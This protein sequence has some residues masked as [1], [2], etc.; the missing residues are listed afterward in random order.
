M[1]CGRWRRCRRP[2]EEPPV[3]AQVAAPVALPS[4]PTPSDGGTKRP[5]LRALK[6]MG[7]TEDEDVR[8]MLLGSRLRKIRSRTWHK[9]RLYRLQEDGL[10]VWFQRRIPR[11]PSQHIFFVQHIEAVREGHQSEGLRRFGGAFAPARCLTIAFKGRRKNLDLAAPTAEEAQRWVRGLTKLRARLDAMSQRER[12]DHW[13][14]SYLHRADSNQDSKMSFKEIKSLLRM[15]NVDMNDMYAYLLF[16]E[17]DH[18]NNDRLEGAEIEEFLRRLLKRPELEEIF[19]QYS[20]EDRVLS[21]PELLEFL[22]DQGEEG[23]TLARAQQLIQTYELN[24]TAKQHELM[25][26]DGF[27]M[28]LLSPEGAA[29]DTTHTC[30]FQDM[31][32]PLA[33]YFISSSHNT[34]LTDSQIG[35]PSSTEAYIRAFAQGCRCVELDCWEGPG[36]E[37]IIYHG[38]T[39]TSKILFRD[40][41]QAVRDHAFTLSP[42]PVILSL[43]NHCGLEQQAAMARHLRTILGDMLVTQ[44]LDSPNPE[45]LPSPEQLKGRVLVK[46][47]KLPAARSEDGRALSD[48]EEEEDDDEEE[49]E[50]AETAAQRRL[51]KQISPELSA[52]VVYCHATRLRTLHPAPDAPQPCQVSSLSERKA[53]KLIREAGNSFVR[54]N[55]RQLTRVYPLGLRMNSANY[56]PQEMW[57]SGC[58]L[59]ALNFQTPG[60]EM[61]LNAGRFLVNGQC[62][63]VLK[64]ACL[65][66]P[67]STFDPEDPG[68]PRTTL[69][70]QV[71]TAQQLP[72]L[73]AE[74][75]HSIVD[76]LVRVEIH[77]VPA[78]CARQETDYVLN[79]GFNP[80]WGQTLQFQL[81][82]PELALVRFVVEDYDA[83][84]PNDFVG[85][86]T[87]PLSSLKQGYRHIHLLSK[88]GASLSPATLFIQIRIQRP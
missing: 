64:P 59:V 35:G 42:Y 21:A 29:L 23:A 6:K 66:Q 1:L 85:Q 68:P 58:Q 54:H 20:G 17:C 44:A 76:P 88:D 55:A 53:K 51:A 18:S 12:L 73:N 63:Y 70:I 9:E 75:P 45:E 78:D 57:N 48:R 8:A 41:V 74:K 13:I 82:A 43:E 2:P 37:P 49:E 61:D 5:G 80:H 4:P 34:Y 36:G 22:E 25:T 69:S 7:L 33:H 11:A 40:V 86:F 16:K 47:K 65:R 67:D 81:R 56:S 10:S 19:H 60:Y 31:N 77:G 62:G 30:V 27:M 39:L 38:H 15:V 28:Y 83:T 24:E 71:L 50:E 84:S 32:Q 14:H 79:N 46:G 72:K 26:L 52:L 3:A 87:L